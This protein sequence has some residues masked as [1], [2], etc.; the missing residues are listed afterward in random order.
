MVHEDGDVLWVIEQAFL[1]RD[2][3]GDPWLIQGVIFDITE[4]KKAEEQVAFLAYHDK[5]TGLPNRALFEEMLEL[6]LARARRH[7]LGRRRAV[8]R[9]GQ[10]QARERLAGAPRRRRSARPAGRAA[11]RLHARDRPGRSPGRRRVP[12][13]AVATSSAARGTGRRRGRRP[14][15]RRVGRRAR[16]RGAASEPFDLRGHRVLRLRVASASACT[17]R[18]RTTREYAA[19]ATPTPRCTG[20]SS[21][22]PGGYVVF[23]AN[24]QDP[25][26]P[27]LAHDPAARRP[28]RSGTGSCTT[29]RSS[30]WRRARGLGRGADPVAGAERRS[31]R[32]RAS[33]SRSPRS[34]G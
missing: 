17:R 12:A 32:R 6:A 34:W 23:A 26:A 24:D 20:P 19:A 3:H 14:A 5:L 29:S 10:L 18:T 2:E 22:N 16:P 33:S 1:I 30:T 28:S 15:R 11:A 4:R 25:R 21:P 9:P 7:E 31:R 27:A 13:A 8:P